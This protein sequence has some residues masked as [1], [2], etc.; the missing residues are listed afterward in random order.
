M[1]LYVD[2]FFA[3]LFLLLLALHRLRKPWRAHRAEVAAR[4]AAMLKTA[5]IARMHPVDFEHHCAAVL[6]TQGWTCKTTRTSGD[7]GVDIVAE[8]QGVRVVIQVKK[9]RA[10]VNLKAV[11]E[12]ATGRAMY[13]AHF[14]AVVSVSGYRASAVK[15]ARVNR[16]LLLSYGDL[17]DFTRRVPAKSA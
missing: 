5:D 12:A 6:K 11:Q 15:L 10:P 13:G 14:A 2:L 17:Y 8:R 9:W 4:K 3:L 1:A 16:V 7:F